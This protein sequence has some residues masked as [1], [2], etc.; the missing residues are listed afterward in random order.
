MSSLRPAARIEDASGRTW[1][2]YAFRFRWPE[3]E[4]SGRFRRLRR[5]GRALVEVPRAALAARSS[6]EWTIEAV[7][8]LPSRTRYTWTTTS[9]YR[10]HVL[11]QVEAGVAG[12]EIPRPRHATFVGTSR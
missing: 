5:I 8:W 12:G 4:T 1:E 9:E 10:G 3:L 7:S 11:A 6:D 2:I